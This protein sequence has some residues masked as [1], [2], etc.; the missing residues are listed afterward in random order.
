MWNGP[1]NDVQAA[2]MTV[3]RG[4]QGDDSGVPTQELV[5]EAVR[6]LSSVQRGGAALQAVG[7]P[8]GGGPRR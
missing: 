6:E 5:D 2:V 1:E 4:H 3:M 7:H 8:S